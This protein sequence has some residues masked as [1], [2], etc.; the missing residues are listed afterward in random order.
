[1]NQTLDA[2]GGATGRWGYRHLLVFMLWLLY[3]INYFDRI[4]VL[5]FL[6]LIRQDLHLTHQQVGLAASIFFFAYALAQVSAGFLADR[7]GARRVMAI[8]ITVF[9]AVTFVTGMVRTFSQFILLRLGLGLGEGHHFAP[10]CK[11]IADWVPKSEKGRAAAF[12][13][14]TWQFAPA[15]IP[16]I[17]TSIAAAT[18]SWRSVFYLLAIPGVVGMFLLFYF[19]T[20]KPEEML[21]RGRLSQD[22]YN[23]IKA[24][25]VTEEGSA[26]KLSMKVI[27]KDASLWLWAMQQFFIL[28]VYWGSTAWL[29]SFLYEQHGLNLRTMGMMASVPYILAFFA[30]IIGGILMDKVFHRTKPVA[31]ISFL[32]SIPILL[33]ISRVPKGHTGTLLVML[34]LT[35]FFVNLVWGVVN[36]YPQIRY[37]KEVVGKVVGLTICIGQMGA[38]ISPLVAG[39]LVETTPAGVSYNKVFLM[40]ATCAALGAV[41]TCLLKEETYSA[42][43]GA[44]DTKAAEAAAGSCSKP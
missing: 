26:T 20:N 8:A 22:E 24:G 15:V 30:T 19:I 13:S 33:Y 14:S 31:L 36:A 11:A 28:A 7:I 43:S 44:P 2:T 40:F 39:Y 41:V 16:V 3:V 17:V 1:M 6:P 35:G 32:T 29:S 10:A 25:L 27:M 23:Y 37:P 4:S 38:F 42:Q 21:K 5:T 34:G 9:T 18:G 12:L